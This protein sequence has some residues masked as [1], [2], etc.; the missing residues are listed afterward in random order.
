VL[1]GA[2][3]SNPTVAAT[4]DRTSTPYSTP[5]ATVNSI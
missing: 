2:A 3:Q 5:P 4:A 1:I